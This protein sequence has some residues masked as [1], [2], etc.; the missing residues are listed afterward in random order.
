MSSVTVKRRIAVVGGSGQ[1][2][3]FFIKNRLLPQFAQQSKNIFIWDKNGEYNPEHDYKL[4]INNWKKF[5]RN[6]E[7]LIRNICDLQNSLI[8]VDEAATVFNKRSF[9][10]EFEEKMIGARHDNVI[11]IVVYHS[12]SAIPE[13]MVQYLDRL[14][15]FKT[16][17][18]ATKFKTKFDRVEI[19]LAFERLQ[20]NKTNTQGVF[21]II[22][23]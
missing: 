23:L 20:N 9:S 21:E 4:N 1:G 16:H 19:N 12:L 6:R 2:K 14:V 11:I 3:S 5:E 18:T 17:E 7:A 13:Y 8:L 22:D 10:Q 15:L